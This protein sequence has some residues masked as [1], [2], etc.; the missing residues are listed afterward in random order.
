[1]SLASELAKLSPFERRRIFATLSEDERTQLAYCWPFWARKEQLPPAGDWTTWLYLGGRGA[2]KSRSG[3]EWVRSQVESGARGRLALVARTAADARDVLV[4]GEAGLLAISP[5]CS[6]PVYEPSKRRLVWASGAVAT[7]FSADEPDQLR[8]P[9]FDAAWAD[10][11]A[12]WRFPEAWSNLMFALRLGPNP[13]VVVTT[14]PRPVKLIRELLA[15]PHCKVT[16]SRTLDNAENLAPGFLNAV[17]GKYAGTRLGRQELDAELLEDAEG[18]LWHRGELDAHRVSKAPDTLTRVVTALDP[19]A[20]AG[21]DEAGIITAGVAS[22][23]CKGTPEVHA[24]VLS[25]DSI[26][27]R[28]EAWAGAAVAAY[29]RF[30]GDCLVCEDNNGGEMVEVTIKTVPDAP[31]VKRIHASRGKLTRAEPVAMLC[32]QGKVH[33]V[34]AFPTLEDELCTY[35]A[36]AGQASPNRLDAFV[37]ALTELQLGGGDV[38][39]GWMQ[40]I[41]KYGSPF[42]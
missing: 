21:G 7:V 6:R 18:A 42:D 28:P 4:E 14:T 30:K 10:E 19:S 3:A 23:S 31:P 2:G 13:Q 17:V 27:A 9:S 41:R 22:C 11:V 29:R 8:G 26:Q 15:D 34:G 24:F 5:L 36:S 25:D 38:V 20:T 12:A 39:R 16:R 37:W 33:F 32:Q 1:V 35:D 40:V